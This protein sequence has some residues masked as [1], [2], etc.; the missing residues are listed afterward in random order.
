LT[1]TRGIIFLATPHSGSGLVSVAERLV[2]LLGT[3]TITNMRIIRVLRKDSEIL[4]RIQSDFYSLLRCRDTDGLAQIEITCFYE[5]LPM[6]GIG[7][8]STILCF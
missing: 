7:E 4:A 1:Y 8:V 6:P 2:R 5:E 3:M